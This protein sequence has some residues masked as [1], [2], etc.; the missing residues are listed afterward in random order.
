M[1]E[2]EQVKAV[3]LQHKSTFVWEEYPTIGCTNLL[4]Y[5]IKLKEGSKPF[6]HR[7]YRLDPVKMKALRERLDTLLAENIIEPAES[8]HS[9]TIILV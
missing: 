3:L 2:Q 6:T 5:E 9:S 1:E 7:A 4:T 8:S